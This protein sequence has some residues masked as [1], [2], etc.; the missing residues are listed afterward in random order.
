MTCLDDETRR[1]TVRQLRALQRTESSLRSVAVNSIV[2]LSGRKSR[3]SIKIS[4][5]LCRFCIDKIDNIILII[6]SQISGGL[7]NSYACVYQWR[8]QECEKGGAQVCPNS[9]P[10]ANT[11]WQQS[12]ENCLKIRSLGR[13]LHP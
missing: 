10:E 5:F 2:P 4:H 8:I 3:F 7:S 6:E 13:R 1:P 9:A 12:I 11:F